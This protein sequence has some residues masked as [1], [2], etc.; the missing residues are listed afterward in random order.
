[1]A[2][3]PAPTADLN[4]LDATDQAEIKRQFVAAAMR[5]DAD[6]VRQI[7]VQWP[8]AVRDFFSGASFSSPEPNLHWFMNKTLLIP[9]DPEAK[10]GERDADVRKKGRETRRKWRDTV[11]ALMDCGLSFLPDFSANF[12]KVYARTAL[13]QITD[14]PTLDWL[15]DKGVFS[16]S[17][18]DD[19]SFGGAGI[20]SA[21]ASGLIASLQD[22]G[23][24]EMATLARLHQAGLAGA[25][26]PLFGVTDFVCAGFFKCAQFLADLG[27]RPVAARATPMSVG[28]GL[29]ALE[30]YVSCLAPPDYSPQGQAQNAQTLPSERQESADKALAGLRLLT[31]WG[32]RL[33][34]KAP[35]QH[36]LPGDASFSLGA[37]LGAG[38]ASH[39]RA[40]TPETLSAVGP[41][42]LALGADP[43]GGPSFVTRIIE[44][45]GREGDGAILSPNFYA[46]FALAWALEHGLDFSRHAALAQAQAASRLHKSTVW[47]LSTRLAG[48][49][50]QPSLLS[51]HDPSPVGASLNV[52]R[53]AIARQFIEAGA[54]MDFIDC[55]GECALH[56]FA[57][58]ATK[59]G[60]ALFSDFLAKPETL[61]LLD[62]PSQSPQTLGSTPLHCACAALNPQN[63]Q[64]LLEAGANPNAQDALGW[65]PLRHLLRKNSAKTRDKSLS[66]LKLLLAHGADPSICDT[67]GLTPAQAMAG[68]ASVELLGELFA[69]R[70]EDIEGK[71]R[72]AIHAKKKLRKRG[73]QGLAWAEK[74]DMKSEMQSVLDTARANAANGDAPTDSPASISPQTSSVVKRRPRSL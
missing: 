1:M 33:E 21:K 18:L 43:N 65:T 74:A 58:N 71:N 16:K 70:P 5:T 42:L 44:L 7:A 45:L 36:G 12:L 68:K 20:S 8:Q 41:E 40:A 38:Y 26:L 73:G 47:P 62:L 22:E 37:L 27:E 13:T 61:A 23:P 51:R 3:R 2:T 60:L 19:V 55:Y 53:F 4:A 69:R 25:D 72:E 35:I 50:A 48:L 11:D 29:P 64:L 6:G 54:P 46:E 49:G 56:F 14:A 32:A 30:A 15:L 66:M 28:L 39:N 9:G 10:P 59:P 52:G 24:A 67:Q 57:R 63:L 17:V 34:L 31:R